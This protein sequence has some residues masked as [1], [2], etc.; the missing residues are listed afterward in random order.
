MVLWAARLGGRGRCSLLCARGGY[1][2]PQQVNALVLLFAL[3][4]EPDVVID[5]DG[6][7]EVALG[8]NNQSLGFHP[9]FPSAS[10]W[11]HLAACHAPPAN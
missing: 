5:I 1:K 10:H 7:N 11:S 8:N 6:F 4:F 2:E 3:G 9:A